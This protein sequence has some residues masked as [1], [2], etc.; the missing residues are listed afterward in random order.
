MV[1]LGIPPSG[2]F[3]SQ[4]MITHLPWAKRD[5]GVVFPTD[6]DSVGQVDAGR[7]A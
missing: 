3:L 7:N 5:S 1:S 2:R 6:E 4:L